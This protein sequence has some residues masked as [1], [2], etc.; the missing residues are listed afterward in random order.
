MPTKAALA[1]TNL[2]RFVMKVQENKK[3]MPSPADT[4]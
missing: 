3:S 2:H 1:P 4:V